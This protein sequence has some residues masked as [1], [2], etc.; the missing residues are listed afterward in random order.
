VTDVPSV[1]PPV[2]TKVSPHWATLPADTVLWRVHDQKWPVTAFK[3]IAADPWF[4]GGR[5]DATST[6]D[7]PNPDSYPYLYAAPEQQ[8]ALLET[9]VRSIPFD[10]KGRRLIRRATVRVTR[11]AAFQ[12][13]RDLL[14]VA[15]RTHTDLAAVCQD[16]WLVQ[17]DPP[18]Y[19]Q[20]RR[21]AHWLRGQAP[22]ADG[23]IWP[24]RRDLGRDSLILF[25]DRCDERLLREV[26]GSSIEL[27]DAD[28]ARWLNKCLDEYRISIR[29]PPSRPGV[30]AAE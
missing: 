5:F 16:E 12:P 2:S 15:L 7:S 8:T 27:D 29:L 24:S 10:Q 6:D 14:L 11:L 13:A 28:G 23:F 4:G 17:A 3:P 26:P 21:W 25:G 22:S 9:L 20:T 19:P 30:M 18:D 1:P